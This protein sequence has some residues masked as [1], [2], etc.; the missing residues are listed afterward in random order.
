MINSKY[1]LRIKIKEICSILGS[2]F[3]M[4]ILFNVFFLRSDPSQILSEEGVS[5]L[6]D[7]KNFIASFSNRFNV[8]SWSYGGARG[9]NKTGWNYHGAYIILKDCI[10]YRELQDYFK[11]NGFR[12]SNALDHFQCRRDV[13]ILNIQS[14]YS[15]IN[16][17]KY[18]VC[19]KISFNISWRKGGNLDNKNCWSDS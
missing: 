19:G 2:L 8:V 15:K 11:D 7:T 12:K 4:A 5:E 13:N 1:F 14:E 3:L 9:L 16:K 10:D 17:D 6:T 18:I